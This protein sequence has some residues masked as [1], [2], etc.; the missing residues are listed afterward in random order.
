MAGAR[1]VA[2]GAVAAWAG[3]MLPLLHGLLGHLH[4]LLNLFVEISAEA[5]AAQIDHLWLAGRGDRRTLAHDLVDGLDLVP[6]D[7]DPLPVV[8]V[9]HHGKGLAR[10]GVLG[11]PHHAVVR[12]PVGLPAFDVHVKRQ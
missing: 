4:R 10:L 9:D 3:G 2:A 8:A 5:G 7:V 1:G 6:L 12:H 11:G